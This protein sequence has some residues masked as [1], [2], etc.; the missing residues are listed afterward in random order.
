MAINSEEETTKEKRKK[1]KIRGCS[2]KV[3]CAE[4]EEVESNTQP[5]GSQENGSI[6]V[7]ARHKYVAEKFIHI[8][9]HFCSRDIDGYL[10]TKKIEKSAQFKIAQKAVVNVDC[11]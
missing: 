2:K 6:T 7:P 1:T 4:N 11:L 5:P 10:S 8:Y 9:S 3:E